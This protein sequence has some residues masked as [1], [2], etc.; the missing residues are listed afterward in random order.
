GSNGSG[1]STLLK[2]IYGMLPEWSNGQKFFNGEN[3]TGQP[4][5]KLLKKGLLYIPQKNNLFETL[6]VKENL[7][8]AGLTINQ[9]IL[10]QR[11]E[12]VLSIFTTL[13]PLLHRTP[14]KLSGGER[15]MLSLGMASLHE[16]RMILV[17]EPLT[18]LSAKNITN[19]LHNLKNLNEQN[20]VTLII[21]EHRIKDVIKISNKVLSL[22]LG[23]VFR[24]LETNLTFDVSEL[25]SVF[26]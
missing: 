2:A 17:D 7:E 4:T 15:Q 14:M 8:M 18:G 5:S 12:N 11:I 21:V 9:R 16:P 19:I 22:K 25:N 24:E 26:I 20:G 1:K 10:N 6:T 3:I 13:V 23:K